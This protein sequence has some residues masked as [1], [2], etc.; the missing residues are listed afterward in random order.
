MQYHDCPTMGIKS[1]QMSSITEQKLYHKFMTP[2]ND[3]KLYSLLTQ[4]YF[5]IIKKN[6]T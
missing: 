1:L 3:L 4:K 6:L 5:T 2:L